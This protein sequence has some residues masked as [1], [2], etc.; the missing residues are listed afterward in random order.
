M[1]Y[2][3]KAWWEVFSRSKPPEW[4]WSW[5]S[6]Q[7]RGSS[8]HQTEHNDMSAFR[9]GLVRIHK[10]NEA[11]ALH[12]ALY[13]HVRRWGPSWQLGTA[14]WWA[15]ACSGCSGHYGTWPCS[16]MGQT[17]PAGPRTASRIYWAVSPM[18]SAVEQLAPSSGRCA[19]KGKRCKEG[20]GTQGGTDNAG[21]KRKFSAHI[22]TK[23]PLTTTAQL[24]LLDVTIF[25]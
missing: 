19:S 21:Q 24:L 6:S 14:G 17:D 5:P 25:N 1:K 15:A 11:H 13:L 3:K 23:C 12:K 9:N 16:W 22:L 18:S 2:V 4:A 10:G 7:H 8:E 20:V